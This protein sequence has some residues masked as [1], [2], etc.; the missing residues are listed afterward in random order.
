MNVCDNCNH[1]NS[2]YVVISEG[3]VKTVL[4]HPVC[5]HPIGTFIKT[6]RVDE[7]GF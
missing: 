1:M 3:I 4:S 7:H 5:T 2:L 6:N